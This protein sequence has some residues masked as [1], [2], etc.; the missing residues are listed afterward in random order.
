MSGPKRFDFVRLRLA[1]V[2]SATVIFLLPPDSHGQ[3]TGILFDTSFTIRSCDTLLSLPHR[4]IVPSSIE[5]QIDSSRLIPGRDFGSQDGE[6]VLRL[7][8][9][10]SLCPA[11]ESRSP[12]PLRVRY[13]Y[14][15]LGFRPSY[16]LREPVT[17][18]DTATGRVD[19]IYR[20]AA[21]FTSDDFFGSRLARSGSLIRGIQA[22]TN[23]DLTLS[24]GF[25]LQ[26]SGQLTSGLDILAALADENTPLQPEGNTETLQELDRVFIELR[27]RNATATL[28]DL[29]LG[30]SSGRFGRLNRKL[31]GALA[32]YADSGKGAGGVVE[33]GGASVRGK[34]TRNEFRGIDGV[35]GPYRLSGKNN[36]TPVIVLAGTERVYI[37]GAEMVRGMLNDYTIEYGLGEITFTSGRRITFASRIVVEF[38]YTDRRYS[39][40]LLGGRGTV[41]IAGGGWTLST[42]AVREGDDENTLAD[43][44]LTD[45]DREIIR[46][47]GDS[48]ALASRSGVDSVGP[49]KGRYELRDTVVLFP[50]D[51]LPRDTTV[52]VFNPGDTTRALYLAVFSP[53]GPGGG[54]YE[55]ISTGHYRYAGPG[56]GRYA[57]LRI[58]PLPEKQAFADVELRGKL[59]DALALTGE[60]AASSYDRNTLSDVGDGDNAG[61][62]Y[63]VGLEYRDDDLS[64]AGVALHSVGATLH[65][66]RT[67]GTFT[68][69]DRYNPV[70]FDRDWNTS[71][72]AGTGELLRE[73]EVDLTPA[74]GFTL[75]GYA[76]GLKRGPEFSSERYGTKVVAG[77]LG[78]YVFELLRSD[79]GHAATSTDRVRHDAAGKIT[80]GR[81]TPALAVRSERAL[82]SRAAASTRDPASYS[83][84]EIVPGVALDSIGGMRFSAGLTFRLDDSVRSGE[85]V[86]ASRSFFQTYGWRL[87]RGG[88]SSNIDLLL[89]KRRFDAA[90]TGRKTENTA[91]VRALTRVAPWGRTLQ[92]DLYYEVSPEQSS[93]FERLFTQVPRG[94]GNYLYAGDLNANGVVDDADFKQTRFDGDYILTVVPGE[95]LI[96]VLNLK[97]SVRI[98]TDLS[99]LGKEAGSF[100]GELLSPVTTETYLRVEEKSSDS[101]KSNVYLM[102]LATFRKPGST[103]DGSV[104]FRQDFALWERDPAFSVRLRF[105]QKKG[106]QRLSSGDELSFSRE[107][108]VRIRWSTGEDLSNQVEIRDVT[109]L[110]DAGDSSPRSRGVRSTTLALE[111]AYRPAMAIES[112]FGISFGDAKNYERS[113]AALNSQR[114]SL[115]WSLPNN[116]RMATEFRREEAVV[117]GES[118]GIPYELTQGRTVGKTWLWSFN[119]EYRLTRF[120]ESTLRYEGRKE[121]FFRTVHTAGMEVRA[122]F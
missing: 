47:A 31:R 76:G 38:E 24:S 67:G 106:Y 113:T 85:L 87:E 77:T 91:Q 72:T 71:T 64:L 86:R 92:G 98:R 10:D 56:R 45:E 62:A 13:R 100:I 58:L 57:P 2:L 90:Y 28:G 22:G 110:V 112:E 14:I 61:G 116:G 95:E 117:A 84:L 48:P 101:L 118:G 1:F 51:A 41:A 40:D 3:D 70:E 42:M 16:S 18:P 122:F 73:V 6:G 75:G 102:R 11:G 27:S 89:G 53:V 43:R 68:P 50:G 104:L 33:G 108:T 20:T 94:T 15:P 19:T 65:Q 111:W 21:D 80:L 4:F 23:R 83:F 96:P 30:F 88:V 54:D 37:D 120:L 9:S 7:H 93:R 36:E 17:L 74:R 69:L 97:S 114:F 8:L 81:F 119:F 29:S 121:Q 12:G 5:V 109:D 78:G 82:V 79:D 103:L 105:F 39:R 49:G 26:M 25:R 115:A 60:Y 52:L 55:K 59:T 32:S 66:R 99:D 63:D 35:Q 107:R 46:A 44:S 34:Y